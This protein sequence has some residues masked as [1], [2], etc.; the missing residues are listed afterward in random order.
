MNGFT[1]P[2]GHEYARIW[3]A[4]HDELPGEAAQKVNVLELKFVN[5]CW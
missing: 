4:G 2:G 5:I 3:S 1:S